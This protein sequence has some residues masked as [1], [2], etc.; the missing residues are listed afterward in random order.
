MSCS[1]ESVGESTDPEMAVD[2]LQK[3]LLPRSHKYNIGPVLPDQWYHVAAG[4]K[5]DH[6]LDNPFPLPECL[7]FLGFPFLRPFSETV[8]LPLISPRCSLLSSST[9]RL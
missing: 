1:E 3:E 6:N 8:P 4:L 7:D 9:G 5:S 2:R